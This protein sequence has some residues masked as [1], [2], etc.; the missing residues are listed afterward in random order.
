VHRLILKLVV[1]N[2]KMLLKF[3]HRIIINLLNLSVSVGMIWNAFPVW[4]TISTSFL[5]AISGLLGTTSPVSITNH[6]ISLQVLQ[7]I[8]AQIDIWISLLSKVA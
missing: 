2:I 7:I 4:L 8:K 3:I 5:V 6:I 1:L